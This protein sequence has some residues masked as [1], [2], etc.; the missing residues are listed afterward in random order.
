MTSKRINPED[1]DWEKKMEKVMEKK[2]SSCMR[3]KG[4]LD[5]TDVIMD[6]LLT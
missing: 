2:I 6:P 5:S 1:E 3:E 4:L